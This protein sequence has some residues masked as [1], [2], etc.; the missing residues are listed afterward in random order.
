MNDKDLEWKQ[1]HLN[2]LKSTADVRQR[3][4]QYRIIHR[5]LATNSYLFKIG[6]VASPLCTFCKQVPE[7][8]VHL[9][10][11]CTSTTD[12]IEKAVNWFKEVSGVDIVLRKHEMYLENNYIRIPG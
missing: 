6:I 11:D 3:W 10:C 1:V 7:T 8:I 4:F 5:I 12:F 2:M 9:F